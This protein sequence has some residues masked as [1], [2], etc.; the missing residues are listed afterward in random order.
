V[1]RRMTTIIAPLAAAA[2]CLFL[3]G[4]RQQTQA[5]RPTPTPEARVPAG[6]G[7]AAQGQPAVELKPAVGKPVIA[8]V[9]YYPLTAE[10]KYII[11]YL[12][13]IQKKHPK[14]IS[15]TVYDMQS[16]E[17]RKK[18]ST[19]GLGCAGVFVNGKTHWE[20]KRGGKTE[21]VD[22]IKRL[23]DFWPRQ[24]FEAV[25]KQ[26]LDQAKKQAK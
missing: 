5:A 10:H 4:C 7:T 9:A 14:E 15:L 8:L 6:G 13:G 21:T 2:C 26:L 22:F 1:S 12:K 20:I 25:I 3:S 23:D 17:G 24:D 11:D 16:P 18:W 19:T